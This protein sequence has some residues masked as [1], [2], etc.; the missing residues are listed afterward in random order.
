MPVIVV[1]LCCIVVTIT[2]TA[3]IGPLGAVRQISKIAR[4]GIVEPLH[5][6]IWNV[7]SRG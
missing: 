6:R 5:K 4:D 7:L 1:V 2:L 3:V